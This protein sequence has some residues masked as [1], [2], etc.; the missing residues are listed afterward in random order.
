MRTEIELAEANRWRGRA[1]SL[2][3]RRPAMAVLTSTAVLAVLLAVLL[4][5]P[6][7]VLPAYP[8]VVL[9][10][11]LAVL[12]PGWIV[13]RALLRDA[14]G[15]VQIAVA[16]A[17]A[18]ALMAGPGI[19][20]LEAHL[21]LDDFAL[22]YA[23]V[24]AVAAGATALFAPSTSTGDAEPGPESAAGNVLLIA[25]LA[26]VL[27]GVVT[28]PFW[29]A[30]R[31]AGDFDD[32]TYASYVREYMDTGSLN[33]EEPFFGT[34]EAV[35]PRMRSNVW[36]I[37]EALI[38]DAAGVGPLELLQ[39]SLRPV[40]TVLAVLAAYA[41]SRTLFR[42]RTIGLLA[43]TFFLGYALLDLSP[44]EGIGRNLFLRISEDKMVG[45][46]IIFPV[47]LIFAALF[48]A[49][50]SLPLYIGF[51]ATVFA[52][53]VVHPMPLL[54]VGA[55]LAVLAALRLVS[56][57]SIASVAGIA[58]LLVA[59]GAA[60][61]W[62][63]VQRQLLADVAPWL[64]ET[65][66]DAEH[67][68]Q[69]FHHIVLGG[70][71]LIS[72]HHMIM[73]PLVLA[74]I[75]LTPVVWLLSKR[76]IGG[77]FVLSLTGAAL[78]LLFVPLF[79]TPV[80]KI[81]APSTL[82]RVPWMVPVAPVLAYATFAVAQR[83][84]SALDGPALRRY[85][86]VAAPGV[87][88]VIVLSAALVV[89]EQYLRV[90]A[91]AF[92]DRTSASS[93]LPG[94][95]GSVFLGG[96]DRAFSANWRMKDSEKK[97]LDYLDANVPRGSTV[98]V[99]SPTLQLLMPAYLTDVYPTQTITR[100]IYPQGSDLAQRVGAQEAALGAIYR[101]A[102]PQ[103]EI[104]SL[105]DHYGV[106]YVVVT[107]ASPAESTIRTLTSL[108]PDDFSPSTGDPDL[109]ERQSRASTYDAWALD[110]NAPEA[111]SGA[112]FTVPQAISVESPHLG[113]DILVAP[114]TPLERA[115]SAR[116]A[117]AFGQAGGPVAASA[118]A[119]VRFG[120]GTEAGTIVRP[121]RETAVP[122]TPGS[123]YFLTFERRGDAA[124]DTYDGDIWLVAVKVNYWPPGLSPVAGT[125]FLLYETPRAVP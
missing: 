110:G 107:R 119:D 94:T 28:T 3:Q 51:A 22:M 31:L 123:D 39:N 35:N 62:P 9:V 71:W 84:S 38:A 44:H 34:G 114:A 99:E 108:T 24:A 26:I 86:S 122:V 93:L 90:D 113:F 120:A 19:I 40:I 125:S 27:G 96:L 85:A 16:P 105:L 17:I 95:D 43:A 100:T 8:A 52:L 118:V 77:Q 98:L 67:L 21:T 111:V 65:A 68:R 102:V 54:Y 13:A 49:K 70:G 80:A 59:V 66:E 74:S 4:G 87:L 56:E 46:F 29:A 124:E 10:V 112:T 79:A 103:D 32:W 7:S 72:T 115:G 76:S 89:Q 61:I 36:V 75:A 15:I 58:L 82:W 101:G 30:G 73:H 2:A 88:V 64:F 50:R 23:A 104:G 45:G 69:E 14:D 41:L 6:L 78:L 33:A 5:R 63:F 55:A 91:G 1:A 121:R 11:A 116:I 81:M 83:I 97:L 53:S 117:L 92:Y 60:S 57:R 109:D 12:L 106:D 25:M 18:L 48:T 20:A 37:S 42:S 47:A